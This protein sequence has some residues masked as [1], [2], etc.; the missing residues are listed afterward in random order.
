[1]VGQGGRAS[2]AERVGRARPGRAYGVL[3]VAALGLGGA[4]ALAG[5]S[6]GQP[7]ADTST[8]SSSTST[9]TTT[10]TTTTTTSP[11]STSTTA[12]GLSTCQAPNLQIV[13]QQSNGAA[14]TIELTITMTNISTAS[15]SLFGYPGMQLL[16]ATGSPLPT[17]VIRGGGP[18]FATAAANQPP[19]TIILAPQAV[20]AFGLSYSDVPVGNE[21]S[22]PTSAKAEITPP[23]DFTSDIVVLAISPCGGGTVHVSPVYLNG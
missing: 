2:A 13:P 10:T 21:T 18:S 15:C 17:M 12:A 9:S 11:P 22:C 20:G 4:L 3:L 7:T 1:M 23:N 16:S 6:S 14:G 8:T 5:C 19:T